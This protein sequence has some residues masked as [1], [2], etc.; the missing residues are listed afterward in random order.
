MKT[1]ATRWSSS[2]QFGIQGPSGRTPA[3]RA[4][5]H[6]HASAHVAVPDV[7]PWAFIGSIAH[8][9]NMPGHSQSPPVRDPLTCSAMLTHMLLLSLTIRPIL[10]LAQ[11]CMSHP[12]IRLHTSA[13]CRLPIHL[14]EAITCW[15]AHPPM[16]G[17]DQHRPAPPT[18][19]ITAPRSMR[20]PKDSAPP[21]KHYGFLEHN[22]AAYQATQLRGLH[23]IQHLMARTCG[24]NSVI[25][26]SCH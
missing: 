6:P 25:M 20:W 19:H 4:S 5:M 7:V 8:A 26:R 2:H 24:C 1:Q 17:G 22:H 16:Q 3:A 23:C 15:R 21:R 9:Y 11:Y 13:Q 18:V 12:N 14:C 10:A